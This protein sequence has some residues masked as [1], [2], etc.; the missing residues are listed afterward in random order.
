[1]PVHP[2]ACGERCA[3]LRPDVRQGGSSPR[4]RG[5]GRDHDAQGRGLRFIPAPA[6]NGR[7]S[8]PTTSKKPVHPR[9]CGERTRSASMICSA[10]GSS[11][12]LRGT[13]SRVVLMS[14]IGRFIPAPAGNGA[15]RTRAETGLSVHPRA[16]GERSSGIPVAASLNG[17]SPRL[18]GTD[19]AQA[20]V[21]TAC[22]FI[23]A[24]AG[25][26]L[27]GVRPARWAHGSSPR[28]RGTE[29][30]PGGGWINPIGSSPRLRGTVVV[31]RVSGLVGRFI[32]APAGNGCP[33]RPVP[34]SPPVHPRAC[35]ERRSSQ[36]GQNPSAGSSP[37][38]RGT[39][40]CRHL[41]G[42]CRR[43]IPAPAGNGS[44]CTR[45][46]RPLPV[47]A[48][49]RG[50]RRRAAAA[51][52]RAIRFIPAPAG[53]GAYSRPAS[54]SAAVHPRACGER[55]FESIALRQADG[56]SPRLRGTVTRRCQPEYCCRFIPAP[57]GNGP[58]RV[59]TRLAGAVHPRACGERRAGSWGWASTRGSSPR[60]RGTVVEAQVEDYVR[61][62]HPRACG[63]RVRLAAAASAKPGS[64]PR[65]RGTDWW[66]CGNCAECRFIPAPAGNGCQSQ[67]R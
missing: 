41:P 33:P 5:T 20:D 50:E 30:K 46:A 2:R 49:A 55:A 59:E 22:R 39:G 12:R 45:H 53:N 26:G 58:C 27:V 32:P 44:A 29:L 42:H 15:P 66:S 52:S 40:S 62:V 18:R 38:L 23:P 16:C 36:E 13:A 67:P 11:P 24:P 60:L 1:M 37:R 21:S 56:S 4:L 47:H 65:L 31:H 34:A 7:T 17:S 54:R 9:A 57:A 35:G 14:V 51:S 8:W 61:L 19:G 64:S 28:L 25:N 3:A 48:R 10:I 43:F 63:E 6:G